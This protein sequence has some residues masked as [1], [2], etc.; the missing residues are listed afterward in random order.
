MAFPSTPDRSRRGPS[1]R[2]L[3]SGRSRPRPVR[4]RTSRVRRTAAALTLLL[5]AACGSPSEPQTGGIEITVRTTGD[6]PDDRYTLVLPRTSRSAEVDANGTVTFDGLDAG[7]HAVRIEDVAVNCLPSGDPTIGVDVSAGE[8]ARG[9]FDVV[10]HPPANVVAIDEA[11]H[12]FHTASG[13]YAPF[14]RLLRND[15]YIV[16]PLDVPFDEAPFDRFHLLVVSNALAVQNVDDWYNPIAPA[17]T[18]AE[19]VAV[20]RWVEDG[21]ALLLIA[22]HMPFPAAADDLAAEFGAAF[23]NGFAFDTTQLR[24]P[25]TCLGPQ[26]VH[27]FRRSDGTLA[28][29]PITNGRGDGERIDSIGTFTGQAFETDAATASLMRFN[30]H[31]ISLMPDTAWVFHDDTPSVPVEGW[32]QG[33]VREAGAGR[34]ALFGEAAMFTEQVCQQNIPM[35]KNSPVAAQNG[36]FALNVVHWLGRRLDP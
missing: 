16:Q 27:V 15:G 29:H 11:H 6:V 26:F 32:S 35:G 17:F 10:C 36:Q 33:A 14:A 28:D 7:R 23:N 1:L 8:V 21:G 3:T 24:R 4:G 20:R 12:N 18:F 25:L 9:E 22:D 34:V 19:N 2:D 30:E 31:S 5:A 13:R